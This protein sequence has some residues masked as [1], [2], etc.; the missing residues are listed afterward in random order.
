MI[1]GTK[2]TFAELLDFFEPRPIENDEQYWATQAVIDALLSKKSLSEDEQAYLHLISMLMVAYDEEQETIPELR[3]IELI[4]TLLDEMGLKQKDL[5]PIFKHE[6]TVS[7]VLS[8]RRSLTTKH[9][10]K[11]AK[12]FGLPHHL[13]F[14]KEAN[15]SQL[16]SFQ[17]AFRMAEKVPA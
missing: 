6:S 14:E 7:S 8:G 3:G 16:I 4:Q 10:D 11:L 5:M 15:V 17:P 1:L 13:F 9:I 12:F 2:L